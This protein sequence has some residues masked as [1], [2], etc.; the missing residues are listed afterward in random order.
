MKTNTLLLV[1]LLIIIALLTI[2]VS[3]QQRIVEGIAQLNTNRS[4]QE[5]MPALPSFQLPRTPIGF[6]IATV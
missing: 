3:Y 2:I 6:K 5:D 4:G 1:G